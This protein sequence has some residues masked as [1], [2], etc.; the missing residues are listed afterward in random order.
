MSEAFDERM[1]LIR[2]RRKKERFRLREEIKIV[3]KWLIWTCVVLWLV[4][5]AIGTLINL[6]GVNGETF[7]P[8]LAGHPA[9]ASLALAGIITLISAVTAIWLMALGYVY[10][11]AR[12]R[13]MN[14]GLW[15][16]LC[17][18]LSWPFFAIG[19]ILYFQVRE[20][21]PFPCPRCST[22]VGARFNFCP[23]CKCNLHPACPNCKREVAETDKF[24][25]YCAQD[26]AKQPE[27]P[28]FSQPA[29]RAS[30][31]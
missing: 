8:A 25:P 20:P 6:S 5:I 10:R 23:N 28:G 14:G 4:A 21:L 31:E 27:A 30:L 7:P 1:K 19:F 2:F 9:L 15:T 13:G 12:R 16:L 17:M 24:C 29:P 18:L 3:P 26:L 11:D 22:M